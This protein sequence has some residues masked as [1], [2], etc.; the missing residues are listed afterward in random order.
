MI[1]PAVLDSRRTLGKISVAVN[2]CYITKH[3]NTKWLRTTTKR[4]KEKE[5]IVLALTILRGCSLGLLHLNGSSSLRPDSANISGTHTSYIMHHTSV[6]SCRVS[7][8]LVVCDGSLLLMWCLFLQETSLS[9]IILVVAV[10]KAAPVYKHFSR[11]SLW[12]NQDKWLWQKS[13]QE[14]LDTEGG[15]KFGHYYN[16]STPISKSLCGDQSTTQMCPSLYSSSTGFFQPLTSKFP[17]IQWEY[18]LWDN[19]ISWLFVVVVEFIGNHTWEEV[20]KSLLLGP[21]WQNPGG[22]EPSPSDRRMVPLRNHLPAK[23]ES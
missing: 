2:F 6:I 14:G 22:R 3:F 23:S 13:V 4:K 7:W 5:N 19:I 15:N 18:N 11:C 9:L 12:P 10:A 8:Q 16:Q 17:A 21:V 1:S 20:T